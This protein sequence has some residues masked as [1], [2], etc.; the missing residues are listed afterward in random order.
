VLVCEVGGERD[1]AGGVVKEEIGLAVGGVV[2]SEREDLWLAI[3]HFRIVVVLMLFVWRSSVML[4]AFWW[5]CGADTFSANAPWQG[6]YM[7]PYKH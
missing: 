6:L 3:G 1:E 7:A 2:D 4:D 5:V